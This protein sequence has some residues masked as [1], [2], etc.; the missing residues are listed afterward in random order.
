MG[1]CAWLPFA[2]INHSNSSFII[3]L[4]LRNAKVSNFYWRQLGC[5]ETYSNFIYKLVLLRSIDVKNRRLQSK[6]RA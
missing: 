2:N 3:C 5:K 4:S 1:L 6:N